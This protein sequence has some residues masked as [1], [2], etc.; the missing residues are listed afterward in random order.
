V[1]I[2]PPGSANTWRNKSNNNTKPTTTPHRHI[3]VLVRY[4]TRRFYRKLGQIRKSIHKK[5]SLNIQTTSINRR[6]QIL[7]AEKGREF[8]FIYTMMEYNEKLRRRRLRR[9]SSIRFLA[10]LRCSDLVEELGRTRP[11]TMSELMKI[12][13]RFTDGEDAYNNKRTRSM[14]PG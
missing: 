4:V 8:T 6:S 7:R 14:L 2:L 11:K 9:A 12:A 13:S 5:F 3:T 10:D 1:Q